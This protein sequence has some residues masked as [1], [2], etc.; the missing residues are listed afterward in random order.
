MSALPS[1][2]IVQGIPLFHDLDPD[3]LAVL[4]RGGIH[5]TSVTAGT[6]LMSFE[7]PGEVAYMIVSGTVKVH[8]EQADGNDV[9]L[10][11]LGAGDLVGELSVLDNQGRSA[12][13][14]TL[15]Q[16]QLLWRDRRT[17]QEALRTSAALTYNLAR[18]LA[19]RLRMANVKF[20]HLQPRMCSDGSQD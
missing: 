6:T 14:V 20:S 12:T 13:V 7:Q 19:Q 1:L 11:I 5:R 17:L 9:I 4:A 8:V 15:T 16:A 18:I 2:E 10:A 3:T